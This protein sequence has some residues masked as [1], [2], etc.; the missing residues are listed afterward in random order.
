MADREA[1]TE[2]ATDIDKEIIIRLLKIIENAKADMDRLIDENEELQF[3]VSSL[4]T[5]NAS[6][7]K[8]ITKNEKV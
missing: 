2:N 5:E 7:S 4:R 8:Q 3:E 6:L 1:A